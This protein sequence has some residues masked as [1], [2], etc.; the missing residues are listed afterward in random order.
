MDKFVIRAGRA[1]ASKII[2]SS[3]TSSTSTCSAVKDASAL[4]NCDDATASDISV[5]KQNTAES[6]KRGRSYQEQW[7]E[8]Y[9][10]IIYDK[11][12][13]KVFCSVCQE[14]LSS[15]APMPKKSSRDEETIKAYTQTGFSSWNKA[16]ERFAAHEKSEVHRF[17]CTRK[18]AID[19]GVNVHALISKGKINE[20]KSA[21]AALLRMISSLRY[22]MVQGLA[23]RGHVDENS[24]YRALLALVAEDNTDLASWLQRS[25]YKWISHDVTNELGSIMAH[26]VLK[27]LV[28]LV[29][30]RDAPYFSVLIDE[31]ADVT[32]HEQVSICFRFVDDDFE[33][34]EVFFGFYKTESTTAETLKNILRDVLT[35]FDI[36]I[37]F[38]RGIA[39]DGAANMT[40]ALS[41]LQAKIREIEPRVIQVHCLA[42]SLNLVVQEAMKV[43]STVRD[44]LATAKDLI[45]FVRASPKRQAMFESLQMSDDDTFD[46]VTQTHRLRPFCPT[47]W[48]CRISSLK[49]IIQNYEELVLFLTEIEGTDRSDVGAKVNG[50]LKHLQSFEFIF[51]SCFLINILDPVEMLNAALQSSSLHLQMAMNNVDNTK[52]LIQSYRT[53]EHFDEIWNSSLGMAEKYQAGEPEQPRMRQVPKRYDSG[54]QPTRFSSPKDYYRQIY[55]QVV[56]TV[57]NSI[58]DRFTQASTSHLKHVESFL[59]RKNKEDEDQDYVT[60]FYKDDFDSNRLIL[61]RDMLLDILKSKCVSPKHFGDLVPTRFAAIRT[62]CSRP[63]NYYSYNSCSFFLLG[64]SSHAAAFLQLF[65]SVIHFKG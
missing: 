30:D 12:N 58:D 64:G 44:Y 49:T 29:K 65:L 4:G 27:H 2:D 61:H 17:C 43:Q 37:K 46:N 31:T 51:M 36:D 62:H 52:E 39:T 10:W 26:E 60:T 54:A 22:L 55:Y 24:N 5:Q 3:P 45:T 23:I 50:F 28:K 13:D 53:D 32:N 1:A 9:G 20:M 63:K 47:R 6:G 35:R 42:H 21:R 59:L 48:C 56:D 41:G 16:L 11:S 14:A 25:K 34:N 19:D 18:K 7:K 40:G 15:G 8:K 57:I 33:I 38:C